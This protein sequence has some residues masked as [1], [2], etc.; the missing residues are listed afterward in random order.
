M[1]NFERMQGNR[2][3]TFLCYVSRGHRRS[4]DI[5]T[6]CIVMH[7]VTPL[8]ARLSNVFIN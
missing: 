4:Q 7:V 1:G 3:A 5:L 2:V 8:L 6:G